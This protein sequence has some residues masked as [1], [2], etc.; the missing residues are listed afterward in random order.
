MSALFHPLN[1]LQGRLILL[2]FLVAFPG[3]TLLLI[4]NNNQRDEAINRAYHQ[5]E[6]TVELLAENQSHLINDTRYFLSHLATN[7]ALQH[8]DEPECGAFLNIVLA[9]NPSYVNLGVPNKKGDLNCNAIPLN[10]KV[11]VADRAYIRRTFDEK[12]FAI[13][14]FQ[15]DRVAGMTSVNFSYP[16][17]DSTN[18]DLIGAVVAVVSL[19]WWSNNLAELKLPQG[20]I[21]YI[22]DAENSVIAYF[23]E[24]IKLL[25]TTIEPIDIK[26]ITNSTNHSPETLLISSAENRAGNRKM[27]LAHKHLLKTSQN[28]QLTVSVGIP[29][30]QELNAINSQF[31]YWISLFFICF[32]LTFSFA[33]WVI[34][35]G[36]LK[37]IKALSQLTKA[38]EAG[39][40]RTPVSIKGTSELV[41]LQNNFIKM[42]TVRLNSESEL[43]KSKERFKESEHY[44][45]TLF[46]ESP[47]G[48]LLC[49]LNGIFVDTN[50]QFIKVSGYA[51]KDLKDGVLWGNLLNKQ[52]NADQFNEIFTHGFCIPFETNYVHKGGFQVSL[53]IAAKI[54]V[55]KKEP[56]IL[57]SIEDITEQKRLENK[58]RRTQKMDAI[59][60]LTN[61]IAHDFN[62]L[63]A[64]ILG[65]LELLQTC[66]IENEKAKN[67]IKQAV[68]GGMRG[69]LL[70]KKLQDI[71]R[72]NNNN[73]VQV[74]C[75]NEIISNH[76]DFIAKS[77]TPAI[78]IEMK[79]A[80]N[81]SSVLI[82]KGDFEDAITNLSINARDAMPLG[83]TLV[84]ET[85][86]KCLDESTIKS[87]PDAVK[88][89]YVMIPVSDNG[90]G[91]S[92]EV[93]DKILEPFFTTKER[94]KG[95][96]LGLSMVYGFVKRS[97]GYINIYS[98]LGQ[99]TSIQ[100][101][102]PR[103]TDELPQQIKVDVHHPV[104]CGNETILV[105][106]DEEMLRDVAVCHLE[107]LGY[108]TCSASNGEEALQILSESNK[109]KLLLSDIIMPG[110]INGYQLALQ[111]HNTYPELKI[112]LTSGFSPNLESFKNGDNKYLSSLARNLLQKPY[113]LTELAL[114]VRA[115]FDKKEKLN[116]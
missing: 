64:I 115:I 102:L 26:P 93:K 36:V 99:G 24:N 52:K 28:R 86:N 59:G 55:Q 101:F 83:G 7:A 13:G 41:V 108:Q 85:S 106:D 88:G 5:A 92:D 14:E 70:V 21:A 49:T 9:L 45:R 97:G 110:K 79:L 61:G 67:W 46:E 30:D 56:L 62:N 4:Q 35:T 40:H 94:G 37:P 42:A 57:L 10:R 73:E 43:K 18:K 76:K 51:L 2:V 72:T 95:T 109:I 6:H 47:T 29:F 78:Q 27:I 104:S 63:L 65:N 114:A 23:P 71:A 16:V 91:M 54:L 12:A 11:N 103:T 20:S 3:A 33:I 53:R 89:D 1:S 87:I 15:R 105:V 96:G 48:L 8:P 74:V 75:L 31:Y 107:A 111:G 19:D 116:L 17:F 69:A 100:M 32:I 34:R 39:N 58:L 44:N 77:L 60:Q 112:L 66:D 80:I 98:E 113:N 84:I 90:E 68:K 22:T 25:G 82:N 81:I 38:L 50:S